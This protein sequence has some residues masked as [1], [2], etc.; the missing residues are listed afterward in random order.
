MAN[1]KPLTSVKIAA[2]ALSISCIV[3]RSAHY[4]D[5]TF[6]FPLRKIDSSNFAENECW[7]VGRGG[8]SPSHRPRVYSFMCDCFT[9]CCLLS[10]AQWNISIPK[11]LTG[12]A[13]KHELWQREKFNVE[14]RYLSLDK[15]HKFRVCSR[16]VATNINGDGNCTFVWDN[17]WNIIYCG[18]FCCGWWLGV[19]MVMSFQVQKA[20]GFHVAMNS[21]F[22]KET[23]VEK[24]QFIFHIYS[25]NLCYGEWNQQST[26][27]PWGF[28][29]ETNSRSFSIISSKIPDV[30]AATLSRTV[31]NCWWVSACG[32]P[33]VWV[34]KKARIITR[35]TR[36]RMIEIWKE[37][38]S[39]ISTSSAV[40]LHLNLIEIPRNMSL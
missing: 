31:F 39:T 22:E 15:H 13:G 7:A 16:R 28:C 10:R 1:R 36:N 8:L 21:L 11:A 3:C 17:N 32:A 37:S 14:C 4:V 2:N 24:A 38:H 6:E 33:M 29:P 18:A 5:L 19:R 40:T 34:Q 9:Y 20:L 25:T 30:L 23:V 27:D 12:A 35:P 26:W